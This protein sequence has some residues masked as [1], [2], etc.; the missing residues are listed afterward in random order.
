MERI[1]TK[2]LYKETVVKDNLF[3]AL[4]Q[5][6]LNDPASKETINIIKSYDVDEDMAVLMVIEIAQLNDDDLDYLGGF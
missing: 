5:E 6:I 1:N 4:K 2:K 3:Q